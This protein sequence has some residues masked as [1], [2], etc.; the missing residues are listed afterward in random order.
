MSR[1]IGSVSPGLKV[2]RQPGTNGRPVCGH[3]IALNTSPRAWQR[4]RRAQFKAIRRVAT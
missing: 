4:A 1:I 2:I 3:N